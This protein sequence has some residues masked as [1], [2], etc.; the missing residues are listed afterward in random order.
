MNLFQ[1][2]NQ[3]LEK[4]ERECETKIVDRQAEI[5]DLDDNIS[6]L[7]ESLASRNER[8]LFYRHML[9]DSDKQTSNKTT[10]T[11]GNAGNKQKG[12]VQKSRK[13]QGASLDMEGTSSLA[14]PATM[15]TFGGK[16]P[17]Y[18]QTAFNLHLYNNGS[19]REEVKA[20]NETIVKLIEKTKKQDEEVGPDREFGRKV[21]TE[22]EILSQ[23]K[24]VE[25]K[26]QEIVEMRKVYNFFE[27]KKLR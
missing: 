3:T 10:T 2:R 13:D 5:T 22:F 14:L 21:M 12:A 19:T 25:M 23:L 27:P 6:K 1:D 20:I 15:S 7:N 16:K 9:V 8:F 18:H 11:R 17:G 24:R 4:M 26:F